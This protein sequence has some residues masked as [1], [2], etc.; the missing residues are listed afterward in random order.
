MDIKIPKEVIRYTPE[1]MKELID[2]GFF[3]DT[4]TMHEKYEM[5]QNNVKQDFY[6]KPVE[7]IVCGCQHVLI[8][9]WCNI[10]FDK[11]IK[12]E[13]LNIKF[14]PLSVKKRRVGNQSMLEML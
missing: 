11:K 12:E 13:K 2:K 4:D 7:T 5:I 9:L 10:C 3:D 14:Q 1:V 6:H 8:V